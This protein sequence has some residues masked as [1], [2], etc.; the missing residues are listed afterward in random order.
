M[1][2]G[3]TIKDLYILLGIVVAAIVMLVLWLQPTGVEIGEAA[4]GAQSKWIVPAIKHIHNKVE[5]VL[6]LLR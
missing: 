1:K 2:K 6:Q 3:I 4:P 5:I